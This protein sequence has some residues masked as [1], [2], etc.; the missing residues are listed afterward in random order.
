VG[1]A[2]IGDIVHR[3]FQHQP[4]SKQTTGL[5]VGTQAKFID[6]ALSAWQED[7]PLNTLLTVRW[8]SLLG[9]NQFHPFRAMSAPTQIKHIVELVRH[10]LA[11]QGRRIPARYIWV[12]E[13]SDEAGGE[14][15]HFA[16]HLPEG[17]RKA[18]SAYLETVLIEQLAPC[19]RPA[20]K[21]TRGEYACSELGSWHLARDVPG[22]R[23]HFCGYF[24]AAYLGKGEPSRRMFRGK[25]VDNTLKPV[26]GVAFGGRM[27][28]GRYDVLQG[29]ITGTT[30]RK[31]RYDIARALK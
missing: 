16:F 19:P 7:R 10:W 15:W 11:R 13:T 6:A 25:L 4:P 1:V 9:A 29:Q 22:M 8:A 28:G 23:G 3:Y 27:P 21:Q 26:R 5:K 12:R 17:K 30:T 20:S 2:V 14:H 18:F 31:G 24:T